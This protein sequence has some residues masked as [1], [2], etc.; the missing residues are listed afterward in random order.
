M[1]LIFLMVTTT[2]VI[3]SPFRLPLLLL[4]F[5]GGFD[6]LVHLRVSGAAAKISAESVT[7]LIFSG[8]GIDCEQMLYRHHETWGAEAALR[9]SPISVSFLDCGKRAVLAYAF[10]SSDLLPLAAGSEQRAGEHGNA[11]HENGAR[12]AGR[13]ITATLGAGEQQILPQGVKQQLAGLDGE[14]AG[15]AVY[16]E[17]DEFFLH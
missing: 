4:R 3:R 14:L 5:D 13:I 6:C 10:N 9:A 1:S 12:T 11:I 2:K 16:P 8:V 7:N 15:A 17:F